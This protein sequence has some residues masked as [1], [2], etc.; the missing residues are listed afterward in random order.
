MSLENILAAAEYLAGFAIVMGTLAVLWA[1]TAL[2][3]RVVARL[4]STVST[5]APNTGERGVTGGKLNAVGDDELLVVAAVTAAMID[6]RHR[7]I[8]VHGSS[9]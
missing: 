5:A 9:K 7:I 2:M 3:G 4:G 1:M 6:S 8:S